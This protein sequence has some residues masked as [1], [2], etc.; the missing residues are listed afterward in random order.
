MRSNPWL[1]E[2]RG[3]PWGPMGAEDLVGCSGELLAGGNKEY[4]NKIR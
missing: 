3:G 4:T 2:V 1:F